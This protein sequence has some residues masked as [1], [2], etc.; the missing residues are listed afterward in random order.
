MEKENTIGRTE[1]RDKGRQ[2]KYMP[3]D[4]YVRKHDTV[5]YRRKAYEGVDVK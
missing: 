2:G 3:S 5:T 1:E 4:S